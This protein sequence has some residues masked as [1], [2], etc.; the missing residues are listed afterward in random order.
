MPLLIRAC[1]SWAPA[2]R[3]CARRSFGGA[4]VLEAFRAD[5]TARRPNVEMARERL[6]AEQIPIVGE[7]VGGDV[8][9]KL[10]FEVQTGETLVRPLGARG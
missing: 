3:A 9:R 2:A 5:R 7:D 10:V 6:P 1:S 8:G 4:C